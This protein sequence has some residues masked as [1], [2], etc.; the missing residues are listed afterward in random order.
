MSDN[1]ERCVCDGG[2]GPLCEQCLYEPRCDR[3]GDWGFI[4]AKGLPDCPDCRGEIRPEAEDESSLKRFLDEVL[5]KLSDPD[6][7]EHVTFVNTPWDVCDPWKGPNE[8]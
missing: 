3:C 7:V 6:Y 2:T 4:Y 8:D 5:G 1:G